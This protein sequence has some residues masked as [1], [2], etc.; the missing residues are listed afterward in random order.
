MAWNLSVQQHPAAVVTATGPSDIVA[1]LR[2]ARQ[3]GLGVAVQSTGHGVIRPANDCL[4]IVTSPMAD[5][6]V[7]AAAQTAWVEAGAHG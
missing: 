2:F 3:E 7:D 4:L 6:R 5:V 1:A